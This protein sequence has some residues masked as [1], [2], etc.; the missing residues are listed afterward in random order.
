MSD[1]GS[2]VAGSWAVVAIVLV[3][4]LPLI[5]A[6]SVGPV[7]RLAKELKVE[8]EPVRI[9][10]GPLIWLHDHTLLKE[11]LEQYGRLWGI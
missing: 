3:L 11:P 1:S 5:Y 8:E 6:A 7:A 2:A 10:Y 4:T 9:F